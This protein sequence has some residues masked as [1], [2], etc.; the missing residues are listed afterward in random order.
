[1]ARRRDGG[2]HEQMPSSRHGLHAAPAWY[3]RRAP[4]DRTLVGG[5][6]MTMDSAEIVQRA[7]DLA[8]ARE[9]ARKPIDY[10]RMNRE[11]P[12]LKSALTRAG[13]DPDKV[14]KACLEAMRVWDEVGAWPDNWATWQRALDDALPWNARV[15]LDDLRAAGRLPR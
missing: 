8:A 4:D 15:E 14:V 12:R 2:T 6:I 7:R 13:K 5:S 3:H 1:M 9:Q 11:M 10:A